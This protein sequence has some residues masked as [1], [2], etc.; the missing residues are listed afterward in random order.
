MEG[1]TNHGVDSS[2]TSTNLGL[3]QGRFLLCDLIEPGAWS[4]AEVR[5]LSAPGTTLNHTLRPSVR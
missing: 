3:D 4:K 5:V 1:E 2:R